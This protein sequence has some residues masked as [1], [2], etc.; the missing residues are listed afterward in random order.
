MKKL[1]LSFLFT[2]SFIF[3]CNLNSS[4][5]QIGHITY[6]FTDA[7][8][9]NRQIQTEIYYPSA[10]AG[11][12]TTLTPGIYPVVVCGHGFVMATSAYQN[13][14]TALVN[15]GYIVAL[16]NTEGGFAPSH[17]NFGLDL[18]FIVNE[19]KSNGAGTII[20]SSAIGATSA[21]MGHSMGGG[22]SFLA[23][24]NDGV[25]WFDAER[26]AKAD[27]QKI[28]VLGFDLNFQISHP[29]RDTFWVFDLDLQT[30][31]GIF[32]ILGSH[33]QRGLVNC[34][35]DSHQ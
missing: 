9:S 22:S 11:N 3:C 8:R 2:V 10:T 13:I 21:I 15:E 31:R 17:A 28:S 12:N 16:P 7:S 20:P 29:Q 26:A 18:K 33:A 25:Y 5:Q 30:G 14:W 32:F 19:M 35:V 1:K 24:A 34:L 4:A 6:S 27:Q 23:A